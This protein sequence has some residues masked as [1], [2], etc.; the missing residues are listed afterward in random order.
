M[1]VLLH[2]GRSLTPEFG[3]GKARPL[4]QRFELSPHDRRVN[5]MDEWAL[6]EAAIRSPDHVV[7]ANQLGKTDQALSD[8]FGVL[9]HIGGVSDHARN[10][11]FAFR[12]LDVL[13]DAPLM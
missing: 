5:A 7:A 10:E 11:L 3:R 9:N 6:C 13:P 12:Q 8:Q 1:F 4:S 2:R